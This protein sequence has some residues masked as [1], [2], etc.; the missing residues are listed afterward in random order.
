MPE[1]T[2]LSVDAVSLAFLSHHVASPSAQKLARLKYT[3]ALRRV[4]TALENTQTAQNAATLETCLMLDLVE[5]IMETRDKGQRPQRAHLDGALALVQLRGLRHFNDKA[6]LRALSRLFLT[7]LTT[8]LS[9]GDPMPSQIYQVMSHLSQFVPD[10]TDTKWVLTGLAIEMTNLFAQL[11]EGT[12]GREEKIRRCT[13]L[14]KQV[15]HLCREASVLL[16]LETRLISEQ[17]YQATNRFDDFYNERM[18]IQSFNMMRVFRILLCDRILE[19]YPTS[20]DEYSERALAVVEQL[21][22]EICDS[23][24]PM[25][26]CEGAARRKLAVDVRTGSNS[27]HSHTLSHVLDVYILIFPLF[28]SCWTHG[29]PKKSRDWILQQLE[30]IAEHFSVK[31]AAAVVEILRYPKNMSDEKRGPWEVYRLLGSYAFGA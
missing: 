20:H 4:H 21:I 30:H 17:S 15:E 22:K 7:A 28:V 14:D 23:V 10:V 9:R 31:E 18:A 29:C 12:I 27:T 8:C 26:D 6:G 11:K 16:S 19:S 25:A 24:P 5:K 2:N 13:N 3:A 1:H